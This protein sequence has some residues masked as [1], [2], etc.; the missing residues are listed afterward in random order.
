MGTRRKPR[1]SKKQAAQSQNKWRNILIG[2]AIVA[3]VIALGYLLYTNLQRPQP[4]EAI[5]GVVDHEHQDR[6]HVEHEIEAGDLSPVG[7]IHSPEWQ[8]CGI[9]DEPVS[10][11]NAVHSLE[12]RAMWLTY[13]PELAAQ[14]VK[15]LRDAV[16]G[17]GFALMSPYPGL[18]S[19]VVL[20]AWET[21]LE[22]DS[23]DDDRIAEFVDRYQQ[24][25]TTPEPGAPCSGGIGTPIQ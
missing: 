19:P 13:Q 22:L 5:A 21:Q 17:E 12:H 15:V 6:G 10:I 16:R 4:P 7:G 2:G 23:V 20:T 11:E 25:P 18:R 8:N 14:E 3:G 9:Y 24:G 1:Q